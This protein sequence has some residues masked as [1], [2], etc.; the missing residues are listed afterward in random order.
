MV[1]TDGL[2][3]GAERARLDECEAFQTKEGEAMAYAKLAVFGGKISLKIGPE[4]LPKLVPHKGKIITI[5]G[6][7]QY[8]I[9]K[10]T[11]AETVKFLVGEIIPHK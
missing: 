11:G 9:K 7:L 3:W 5:S 6:E 4:D 8:E 2:Y 1:K 10:G